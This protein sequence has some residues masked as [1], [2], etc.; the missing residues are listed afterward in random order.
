MGSVDPESFDT[1]H[2]FANAFQMPFVTPW[3]PE[4][5]TGIKKVL[6][7]YTLLVYKADGPT[8]QVLSK[9]I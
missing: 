7:L 5:A 3:F 4:K 6:K 9:N 8:L 1:L 2:S